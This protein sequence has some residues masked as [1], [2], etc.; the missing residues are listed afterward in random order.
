MEKGYKV[1]RIEQTET[2]A[3]LEERNRAKSG[4]KDKVVAREVCQLSTKGTRVNTFLD[5]HNFEGDPSYL[6]ALCERPGPLFGVAF[7]DTTL[8]CFHLGQFE[9]DANLSRLRTLLA[10]YPP[11]ELLQPRGGLSQA[12]FNCLAATGA[13]RELL[14]PGVEFWDSSK[15]LKVLAE[16]EYFKSEEGKF[17]WPEKIAALLEPSDTLGL[18]ASKIGDLAVGILL[19]TLYEDHELLC[20]CLWPNHKNLPK[21]SS[22]GAVTFYLSSAFLDQQLLSQRRFESYQPLDVGP[23][24]A[25]ASSEEKKAEGPRGKHMV[26]DGATVGNLELLTNST[27]GQEAALINLFSPVTAM[28]KRLLTQWILSP[29]LQPKA[30]QARQAAIKDLMHADHLEQVKSD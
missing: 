27:G 22:L 28:G 23:A 20:N 25:V 2:P 7:V 21:V 15:A 9:D 26:L 19:L 8:A 6:L 17:E 29:L 30:I 3:Q 5:S 11:G 10:H 13:R 12:T 14:R 24:G 18:T 16:R 1:A 4:P